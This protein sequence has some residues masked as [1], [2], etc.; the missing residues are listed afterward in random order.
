MRGAA[1]LL[2]GL[3]IALA[4]PASA[5]TIGIS[6]GILIAGTEPDDGNQVFEPTIVG[7]NL[8]LPSLTADIVT[9]GCTGV[10]TITCPI[11][12]FLE[13]VILG[14]EG[15][16]VI[17]LSSINR[18]TFSIIALGLAG[19][20]VLIGTPGEVNL[21]GGEGDD[22]IVLANGNCASPGP[23]DDLVI[24]SLRAGCAI[25]DGP[26]PVFAPLPRQFAGVPEPGD[27]WLF[28]L[29]LAALAATRTSFRSQRS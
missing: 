7:S 29:G 14:G 18:L 9:P 1:A 11:A 25:D 5:M 16:D 12:G 26:E 21:F 10:G 23:G 8:V 6:D 28:G 22:V 20:D 19:N 3:M 15:D 2:A 27:F 17:D 13:L 4:V 24:R